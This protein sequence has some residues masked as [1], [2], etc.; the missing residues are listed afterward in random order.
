MKSLENELHGSIDGWSAFVSDHADVVASLLSNLISQVS[1]AHAHISHAITVVICSIGAVIPLVL[2]CICLSQICAEERIQPGSDSPIPISAMHRP[3]GVDC[4]LARLTN[5][6]Y[7]KRS[8]A[9]CMD[10]LKLHVGKCMSLRGV[11]VETRPV[12][13]ECCYEVRQCPPSEHATCNPIIH[14]E[15]GLLH[16]TSNGLL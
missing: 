8:F 1:S 7:R 4:Y 9:H 5:V 15:L 16:N 6:P 10:E 12:S 2:R 11:I 3:F 13:L 14:R